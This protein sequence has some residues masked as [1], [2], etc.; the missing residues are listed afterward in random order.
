MRESNHPKQ[1]NLAGTRNF[2]RYECLFKAVDD[3]DW[4]TTKAFLDHDPDAVRASISPTNETALHVAILA[5]HAHIVKELVKLMTPKDLELRSGL[6][7]T[8]LTT[9]AISGVTKMAKAIV[10]QYP[11]A[12]C[13]GNEHGQIPVIVASFYDQKDMVRY[14]Y[15]VTPIE[16]LSPEKG[17][18]GAT[19]LNFLVSANIYDIALHLLKHYRHLSFT[20]DYYGNYTVR[21]LARKPSAFLSGSKLLFWERWIYSC[22]YF[23]VN[24]HLL[25]K[26]DTLVIAVPRRWRGLI[27]KLLLRFGME[28]YI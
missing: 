3:G 11:S 23:I 28:T 6:G 10:E 18:N 17:T 26:L 4:V 2:R 7:E 1:Q 8:A 20:K 12:V 14:L 21:M 27:W 19:L 15:S 16:E 24:H 5:G 13:V 22:K 9:A 25:E